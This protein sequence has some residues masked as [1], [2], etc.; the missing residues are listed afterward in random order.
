MRIW[1]L[2]VFFLLGPLSEGIEWGVSS[3]SYQFE[4]GTSEGGRTWSIWDEFAHQDN[5]AHIRDHSNADMTTNLYATEHIKKDIEN[6][7]RLGI[8]HY[9]MSLSWSRLFPDTSG[10]MNTKGRL[11]Y[12]TVFDT[13][14]RYNMTPWVTLFHWDAPLYYSQGWEEPEMVQ[15][16]VEYGMR[17]IDA[18]P[19]VSHWITINEI[20]T[21]VE[22]G[23][24]HG[25]HAPGKKNRTLA[26]M[27]AKHLLLGHCE[28]YHAAKYLNPLLSVGL[29][30][31]IDF[32]EPQTPGDF[33][34]AYTYYLQQGWYA[35]VLITG[36]VPSFL[37]QE[38]PF[39]EWP[40][41][42]TQTMDFFGLNYYS[43]YIVKDQ[44]ARRI[45]HRIQT[46]SSWL[47]PYPQG[48]VRFAEFLTQLYSTMTGELEIVVTETGMST[49]CGKDF[50]DGDT[51][52]RL[53]LEIKD[54]LDKA[55][56]SLQT[57][58]PIK[59]VFMWSHLDNFEWNAGFTECFGM[60]GVNFTDNKQS[61]CVKESTFF[62]FPDTHSLSYPNCTV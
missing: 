41:P 47:S 13:L 25:I 7:Y 39:L 61:R 35:E 27:V 37:L 10:I 24:E 16:F 23:Y 3:S 57:T 12:Q 59:K 55:S 45:P 34:S 40:Y 20:R 1:S 44:K 51:R 29:A 31:N 5:G 33:A 26:H 14:S 4:G 32:F 50:H 54:T 38:F 21:Y 43:G 48:I 42:Q 46:A 62:L 15:R 18:F 49:V 58:W 28:L 17:C 9:R 60:W 56:S 19:M 22:Q 36:R 6:L 30:L 8:Q 52:G 53:F 11:Y 2:I